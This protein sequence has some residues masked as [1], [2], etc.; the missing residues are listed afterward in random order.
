MGNERKDNEQEFKVG[1]FHK[2]F[3]I[4]P[5]AILREYVMIKVQDN[6]HVRLE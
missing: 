2:N 4:V 1:S 3:I 5:V 6:R